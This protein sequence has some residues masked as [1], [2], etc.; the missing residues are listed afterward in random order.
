[1]EEV[2]YWDTMREPKCRFQRYVA[3]QRGRIIAVGEYNQHPWTY[4]RQKFDIQINV[5]P[6][7]QRRGLGSALYEH[8]IAELEP[9]DPITVRSRAREDYQQSV[10]FVTKRGFSEVMRSWES[11][12]NVQ[13]FDF[14]PYA[15]HIESVEA[16]GIRLVP[17]SELQ[18]D[19]EHKRKLYELEKELGEDVPHVDTYT[20]I[21]FEIYVKRFL[22]SPD[23]FPQ[24]WYIALDGDRYAGMSALWKS[25]GNPQEL[26]TGLTGVQR[27]YR[28]R[29]IALALKLQTIAH[30]KSQG[31]QTLK[32]WNESNNRPMLSIN[33]RLGYVKQPAWIVFAKELKDA[34]AHR[35]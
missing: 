35:A 25:Q 29:G 30:A 6:D 34:S 2:R 23:L 18:A 22:Q 7:H 26:Y 27:E 15:G 4:H 11:R 16:Q 31:Y 24:A 5:H 17:L 19:P 1:V 13:G 3:E 32:T 12:L 8:L 9:F 14:A 33:E 20:P 28:R 21:S 10:R